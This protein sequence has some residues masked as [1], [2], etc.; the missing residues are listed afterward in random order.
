MKTLSVGLPLLPLAAVALLV[1][2]GGCATQR[3]DWN[4]RVGLYTYDQ[5]IAELGPPDKTAKLTDGS[6]VAEWL[7]RRVRGD[8]QVLLVGG[9][10]YFHRGFFA[11]SYIVSGP[12]YERYL[13]LTFDPEGRL[14]AWKNVTR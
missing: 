7:V 5:A 8:S 9:Y 10:G 1:L 13:R 12:D 3:V 6:T 4:A 2:A 11:P 14:T